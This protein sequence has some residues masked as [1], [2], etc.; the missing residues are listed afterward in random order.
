MGYSIL[1]TM[2]IF[3]QTKQITHKIRYFNYTFE[4]NNKNKLFQ[5]PWKSNFSTYTPSN[6]GSRVRITKKNLHKI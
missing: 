3:S 6:S 1:T 5:M 2:K 4:N